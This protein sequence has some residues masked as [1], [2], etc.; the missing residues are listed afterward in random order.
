M[1]KPIKK[2]APKPEVIFADTMVKALK[3]IYQIPEDLRPLYKAYVDK[4]IVQCPSA[5]LATAIDSVA[6]AFEQIHAC[7]E[8]SKE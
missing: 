5:P 3:D 1:V 8:E 6:K 4:N 2:G 7:S